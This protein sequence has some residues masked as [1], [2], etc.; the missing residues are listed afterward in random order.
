M[1][2]T[3]IPHRVTNSLKAAL[4]QRRGE[5]IQYG[6]LKLRYL[7]GTRPVR[8]HYR[9]DDNSNV[10]NDVRQIEYLLS[11][12][13]IGESLIDI[14]AHTGEYSVLAAALVGASGKVTAFEPDPH[15]RKLLYRNLQLNHQQQQVVVE[16][17]AISNTNGEH[18][19]Y[20]KGGNSQSSLARSGVDFMNG[21][22]PTVSMIRVPTETLDNYL[23]RTNTPVPQLLKIDVEG[24]E[25]HVLRGATQIL[26]SN[27]KILCELHPFAWEEFGVT[28]EEILSLAGEHKRNISYLDERQKLSDGPQ[29]GT[30]LIAR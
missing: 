18:D 1:L 22:D 6:D 10:R 2:R 7:P 25:V 24:A 4:Y 27:C 19:F 8:L 29:Y 12:L 28:F 15:A 30:L 21:S 9:D 26:K 20:T 3:L 17:I 16:N 11:H 23:Q 5:P 14:G 13:Q